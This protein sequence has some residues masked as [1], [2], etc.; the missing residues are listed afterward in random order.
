MSSDSDLSTTQPR[1]KTSFLRWIG[2]VIFVPLALTYLASFYFRETPEQPTEAR[3]PPQQVADAKPDLKQAEISTVKN[4]QQEARA[5]AVTL[6]QE[7]NGIATETLRLLDDLEAQLNRWQ[8]MAVGLLTSDDGRLLAAHPDFVKAFDSLHRTEEPSTSQVREHRSRVQLLIRP[9]R[10]ALDDP[11][12]NYRPAPDVLTALRA[13]RTTANS[14]LAEIRERIETVE[15]MIARAKGTAPSSMTLQQAIDKF[16]EDLAL[17]RATAI[18]E[19]VDAAE[20]AA[21]EEVAEMKAQERRESLLRAGR[22]E[23]ARAEAESKRRSAAAERER[24][25][26]EAAAAAS[27]AAADAT[28]RDSEAQQLRKRAEDPTIQRLYAPFLSKGL[29]IMGTSPARKYEVPRPV[30]FS[31][32]VQRG[33]LSS[34]SMFARAGAGESHPWSWNDRPKWAPVKTEDDLQ[35]YEG[36]LQQ[37]KELAPIWIE[38]GLLQK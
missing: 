35:R 36:L 34:A 3:W 10:D 38:M 24:A 32:L 27:Q 13:E 12:S 29:Y 7:A 25:G 14:L 11:S 4:V 18:A 31:G 28:R 5:L 30:S 26:I 9:V 1:R 15:Q 8:G 17:A 33:A 20:R 16:K 21:T 2:G 22:D 19:K 23:V 6:L 37:F